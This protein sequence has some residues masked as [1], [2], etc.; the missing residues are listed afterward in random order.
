MHIDGFIAAAGWWSYAVVFAASA[1]GTSDFIGLLVP[2]ET[3]ILLASAI[4]GRGDLN[5]LI[6]AAAVVTGGITG[7]NLGY[8]LGRRCARHPGRRRSRRAD[9]HHLHGR[10][11]AFLVRHGGAAVFTGRFIGFVRTFLP[12][13]AGASGMP[14]R[15]F[16]VYSTAAAS[17]VWGIGTVLLGYFAGA[18]AVDF[19]HSAGPIGIAVLAT[20][21]VAAYG[22]ERLRRRRRVTPTPSRVVAYGEAKGASDPGPVHAFTHSQE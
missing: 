5:V 20:A 8:A 10:A 3:V 14:Y 19:L 16:F 6:L 12:Y 21:T 22:V 11:Q 15:R 18:A 13:A 2:G 9:R 4:A 7:D 17:L 1:S